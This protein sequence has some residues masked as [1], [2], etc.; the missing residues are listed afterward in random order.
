MFSVYYICMY[1]FLYVCMD[2]CICVFLVL[3]LSVSRSLSLS[4]SRSVYMR[5]YIQLGATAKHRLVRWRVRETYAT[6]N[7]NNKR[8]REDSCIDLLNCC[9]H[10]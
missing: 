10:N 3:S 1:V 7:D 4:L 5:I 6:D 2:V 8:Q 9:I